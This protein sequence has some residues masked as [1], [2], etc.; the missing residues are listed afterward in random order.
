MLEVLAIQNSKQDF[1]LDVNHFPS[2]QKLVLAKYTGSLTAAVPLH[3]LRLYT[4]SNLPNLVWK[5][6]ESLHVV[7]ELPKPPMEANNL[8]SFRITDGSDWLQ[9]FLHQCLQLRK[10][11]VR[12][13]KSE[14]VLK[15][16]ALEQLRFAHVARVQV[17][18]SHALKKLVLDST[19]LECLDQGP[20]RIQFPKLEVLEIKGRFP[21][22][23]FQQEKRNNLIFPQVKSLKLAPSTNW[24][25]EHV[26]LVLAHTWYNLQEVEFDQLS[27]SVALHNLPHLKQ[28]VVGACTVLSIFQCSKLQTLTVHKA[29][30]VV[31]NHLPKLQTLR[32]QHCDDLDT[33]HMDLS[34]LFVYHGHMCPQMTKM[35]NL[36]K[37]RIV[38]HAL[39]TFPSL[40]HL[41]ELEIQSLTCNKFCLDQL[42]MLESC[43]LVSTSTKVSH[44]KIAQCPRLLSLTMHCLLATSAVWVDL[45]SL[46][47]LQQVCF[48]HVPFSHQKE[49]QISVIVN[50]C[51]TPELS[52]LETHPKNW[53]VPVPTQDLVCK[54]PLF[55]IFSA[56]EKKLK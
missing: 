29:K 27:R 4:C 53:V 8:T 50:C 18:H 35:T 45:V 22:E 42:P 25:D 33:T 40:S 51:D 7:G 11:D 14:L 47:E 36:I 20:Y 16:L 37:A 49:P 48:L 13:S 10:V 15:Q 3:K 23:L 9:S 32:V 30:K 34:S 24:T 26:Q 46:K 55:H 28:V 39:E 17:F 56:F 52:R 1:V 2:L 44:F 12:N 31:L 6:V 41:Q 38:E 5:A 21:I 43:R 54:T 19:S